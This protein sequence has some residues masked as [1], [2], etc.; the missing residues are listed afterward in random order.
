MMII[1][2]IKEGWA[3]EEGITVKELE[4]RLKKSKN[5]KKVDKFWKK[6]EKGLYE[7]NRPHTKTT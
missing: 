1:K 2:A 7:K 4:E 6:L 3:K 5:K